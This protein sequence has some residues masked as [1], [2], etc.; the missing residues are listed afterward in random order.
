MFRD[1]LFIPVAIF[2]V[3]Y[4]AYFIWANKLKRYKI[5]GVL[6]NWVAIVVCLV[7]I[8]DA[9]KKGRNSFFLILLLMLGISIKKLID[10]T[11]KRSSS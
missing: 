1:P 11:K 2:L 7:L 9:I 4:I 6:I 8:F 10:E 5:Y 3:L